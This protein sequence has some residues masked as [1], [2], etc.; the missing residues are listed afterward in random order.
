MAGTGRLRSAV[1]TWRLRP[2]LLEDAAF[3]ASLGVAI[4]EYFE[5]NEGTAS[6]GLL[7][8]DAFKV[9]I[10]GHCLGTQC[11][12]RCSIE[13]D[14]IQVERSVLRLEGEVAGGLTED[15]RLSAARAVPRS[16]LERL[17]CLNYTAHSARTHA[18]AD[19]A[20]KLLAW[21]TR[22]DCDRGRL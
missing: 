20:G 6:S 12:L 10:R 4:P 5:H 14:L 11:N 17:R 9:F 22:R 7:E 13:G 3:W 19:R 16:L 8:W 2:E 15:Q 1:P 21:L 18:S